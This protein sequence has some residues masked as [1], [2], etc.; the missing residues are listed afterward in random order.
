MRAQATLDLIE[1]HLAADQ[2]ARYRVLLKKYM[3]MATDPFNGEEKQFRPH[4]GASILGRA[5]EREVWYNFHW[6]KV[7]KH[8]G[9][10]IRLFNRGHLEE[11]RFLALLE[12]IGCEVWS[13]DANGRQ[14]RAKGGHDSGSLD[15]VVRGIPE[16]RDEALLG[17]FKTYN[18]NSF[19]KLKDEGVLKAKWEHFCQMQYYMGKNNLRGALYMAVNKNT[20][21]ITTELVGF[22]NN[23]YY[24]LTQKAVGIVGSVE[25]PERI[26]DDRTSFKCKFCDYKPICHGRE[27][28]YVSCRTCTH[29]VAESTGIWGCTLKDQVLSVEMQERGCSSYQPIDMRG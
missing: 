16:C 24:I 2:G 9:R 27:P 11:P 7:V 5:C 12:M 22:D 28:A 15:C 20:D 21:E 14:F 4:L 10:M 8:S 3:D 19:K 29:A 26:S 17:E 18:D 13:V 6:A 23:A 1:K 25:P